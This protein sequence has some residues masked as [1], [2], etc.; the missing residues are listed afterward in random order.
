MRLFISLTPSN[1]ASADKLA[2]LSQF[3]MVAFSE[4]LDNQKIILEAIM[5]TQAQVDDLMNT[6]T[7]IQTDVVAVLTLATNLEAQ[8]KLLQDSTPP[9]IDLQPALDLAT[10]IRQRLETSNSN[11]AT[12]TGVDP[13]TQDNGS[14]PPTPPQDPGA[15]NPSSDNNTTT[16]ST[17]TDL[18]NSNVDLGQGSAGGATAEGGG[19]QSGDAADPTV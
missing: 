1:P 18:S 19:S 16:S 10:S 13:T 14:G 4:V 12:V 7:A 3:V 11:T 6:M 17:S 8:L 15:N 2:E 9:A 5:A